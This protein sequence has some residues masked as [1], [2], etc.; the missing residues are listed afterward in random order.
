M[1][2][3]L[4][5]RLSRVIVTTHIRRSARGHL[6]CISLRHQSPVLKAFPLARLLSRNL[7]DGLYDGGL[8]RRCLRRAY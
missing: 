8:I 2:L 7:S 6:V 4:Q 5:L 3:L 1:I